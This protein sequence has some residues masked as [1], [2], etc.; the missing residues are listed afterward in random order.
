M[1]GFKNTGA[2]PVDASKVD[3]ARLLTSMGAGYVSR[4]VDL[5]RLIFRPGPEARREMDQPGVSFGSISN[6]GRAVVAT[7]DSVLAAINEL[8]AAKEAAR[9]AKEA[10]QARKSDARVARAAQEVADER[11]ADKCRQNPSFIRRKNAL[12]SAAKRQRDRLGCTQEY[13][14]AA[15]VVVVQEPVRKRARR[16]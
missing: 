6:R 7:S 4:R 9:K 11:D 16:S 13:T 15:G 12:R 5:K 2:W 3:V 1:N 8:D 14:P 10:R